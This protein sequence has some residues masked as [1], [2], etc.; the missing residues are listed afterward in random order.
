[1]RPEPAELG[2]EERFERIEEFL[3]R[4]PMPFLERAFLRQRGFWVVVYW[5]LCGLCLGWWVGTLFELKVRAMV[6]QTGLGMVGFLLLLWVHELLHAV[7][8]WIVGA[9]KVRF[10][11]VWDKGIAYTIAPDF[12]ASGREITWLALFPF[13]VI[14]PVLVAGMVVLAEWKTLVAFTLL[15]H[16][17]ACLGDFAIVN[18]CRKRKREKL[19]TVDPA[20][21][22]VSYFY[23]ERTAA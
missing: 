21:A 23:R 13:A 2:D 22:E 6:M 7:A 4:E 8:Y 9:K 14:T 11:V 3:H 15:L 1:M 10:V 16:T 20:G 5:V 19:W 18:Y 17:T 12:V